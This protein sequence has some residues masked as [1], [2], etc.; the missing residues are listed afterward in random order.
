MTNEATDNKTVEEQLA[1]SIKDAEARLN[2]LKNLKGILEDLKDKEDTKLLI[3]NRKDSNTISV[4]VK[5]E[6]PH[7]LMTQLAKLGTRMMN[8]DH[9]PEMTYKP[10]D[11][12]YKVEKQFRPFR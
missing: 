5:S 6:H 9:Q 10:T 4:V 3:T 1:H 8:Y 7:D 2:G 11:E 12:V